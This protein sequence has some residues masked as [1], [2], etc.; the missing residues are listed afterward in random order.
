MRDHATWVLD[1][2]AE[3]RYPSTINLILAL[4]ERGWRMEALPGGRLAWTLRG[5]ENHL[6]RGVEGSGLRSVTLGAIRMELGGPVMRRRSMSGG[7]AASG[8]GM[9]SCRSS[10]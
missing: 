2:A 1:E 10:S 3:A 5:D 6:A 4:L 7:G 8:V 9:A